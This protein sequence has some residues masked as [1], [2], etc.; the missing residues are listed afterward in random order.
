[1]SVN[2]ELP[3]IAP[4]LEL[5]RRAVATDIPVIGHCLGAQL[6]A[7]A[8]G[9]TVSK[10]PVKEIGW[11]EVA[12]A[13]NAA[14]RAWFGSG[15]GFLSFHW[16]GETFALPPGATPILS[17]RYCANQAFVLGKHIGLQCHVEMSE[18]MIRLWNRHWA[19][20]VNGNPGPSVQK[21]EEMY[22]NL[23]RRLERL[24]QAADAIYSRWIAGLKRD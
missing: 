18:A 23:D 24:H 22:E 3:W 4:V 15:D 19:D 12:V 2:D 6:M 16:H 20:E 17:S 11:G 10:N 7:K 9:A 5:I 13:D 21:P 1:M 14:A 8:L